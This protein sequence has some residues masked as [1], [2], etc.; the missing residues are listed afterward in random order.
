MRHFLRF[1]LGAHNVPIQMG[2]NLRMAWVVCICP[3][4]PCMRAGDERRL[5]ECPPSDEVRCG[6]QYCFDD[7][8]GAM[9]LLMWHPHQQDVALCCWQLLDTIDEALS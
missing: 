9:H 5:F 7:S 3:L 6:Y 1:W 2:K 8:Q 4:C